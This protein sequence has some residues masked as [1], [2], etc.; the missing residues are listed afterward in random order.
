MLP[1]HQLSRTQT[2][3]VTL[4]M[5]MNKN[6]NVKMNKNMNINMNANSQFR[7]AAN[8]FPLANPPHGNVVFTVKYY[9]ITRNM[10]LV[11]LFRIM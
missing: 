3:K 2:L 5:N 4:N 10:L 6:I 11:S 9:P 1:T 7:N 8:N